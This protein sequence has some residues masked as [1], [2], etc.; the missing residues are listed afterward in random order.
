MDLGLEVYISIFVGFCLFGGNA[1]LPFQKCPPIS[2]DQM[3]LFEMPFL[4]RAFLIRA[5]CQGI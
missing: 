5:F 2:L 3:P 1:L 4:K